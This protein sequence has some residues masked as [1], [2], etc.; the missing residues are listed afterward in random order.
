MVGEE[1]LSLEF[2]PPRS[3]TP[4]PS[5]SF[6]VTSLQATMWKSAELSQRIKLP[7]KIKDLVD[8]VLDK[9]EKLHGK[10]TVARTLPLFALA[11]AGLSFC[12][13]LDVLSCDDEVISR[14]I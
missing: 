12:E 4:P 11:P 5:T 1:I 14:S 6:V 7:E 2:T 8:M 9:L 10:T 3:L 13:L